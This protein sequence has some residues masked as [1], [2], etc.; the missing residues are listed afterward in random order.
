MSKTKNKTKRVVLRSTGRPKPKPRKET[1]YIIVE[2]YS[3][4]FFRVYGA[5]NVRVHVFNRLHISNST[6]ANDVDEFHT[7]SMPRPF[8]RIYYPRNIRETGLVKKR[9]IEAEYNRCEKLKTLREYQQLAEEH[10]K[11]GGIT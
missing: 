5:D 1:E 8:R 3:D 11:G 9:T 6:M 7:L 4:S 10:K 2:L